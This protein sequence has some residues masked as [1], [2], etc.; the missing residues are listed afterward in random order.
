MQPAQLRDRQRAPLD[1]GA[2]D[3]VA[4]LGGTGVA[5]KQREVPVS[6]SNDA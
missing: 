1:R 3:L 4:D 5:E 6:G 2:V